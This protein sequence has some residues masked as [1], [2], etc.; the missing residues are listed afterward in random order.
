MQL[1]TPAMVVD[2]PT[3]PACPRCGRSLAFHNGLLYLCRCGAV[4]AVEGASGHGL[5]ALVREARARGVRWL[6]D[7]SLSEAERALLRPYVTA[8]VGDDG[9]TLWPIDELTGEAP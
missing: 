2:S 6:A 8:S 4:E 7:T 1:E 5:L 3:P 9:L